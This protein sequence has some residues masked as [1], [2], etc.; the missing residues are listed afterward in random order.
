MVEAPVEIGITVLGTKDFKR[1]KDSNKAEKI[2]TTMER[3]NCKNDNVGYDR[4]QGPLYIAL[5][6][7]QRLAN[8]GYKGTP[9]ETDCSALSGGMCKCSRHKVSGDIYTVGGGIARTGEFELLCI[10]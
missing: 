9:C 6:Q 2:A 3:R 7:S 5:L 4:S 10:S 1:C 8:R